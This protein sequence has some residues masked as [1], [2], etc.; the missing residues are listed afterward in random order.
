MFIA[1]ITGYNPETHLYTIVRHGDNLNN[2]ENYRATME[3]NGRETV[4][5]GTN[6]LVARFGVAWIFS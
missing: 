1:V 2:I 4:P 3:A 5:T 6:V